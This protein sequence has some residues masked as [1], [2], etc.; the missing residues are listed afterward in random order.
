VNQMVSRL[1]FLVLMGAS[2]QGQLSR[3]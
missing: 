1:D 2:I 3:K